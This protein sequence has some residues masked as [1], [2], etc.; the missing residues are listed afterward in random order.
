[1]IPLVSTRKKILIGT[2]GNCRMTWQISKQGTT[3]VPTKKPG[4]SNQ[5]FNRNKSDQF[6]SSLRSISPTPNEFA[7]DVP[8]QAAQPYVRNTAIPRNTDTS[9][10]CAA[11]V[12][13]I[14]REII[15]NFRKKNIVKRRSI[16]Y[17]THFLSLWLLSYKIH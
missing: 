16:R 4:W 13:T 7:R 2:R 15:Y 5:A 1:M 14:K 8:R 11:H 17:C 6:L 9:L 12:C 10:Q 3:V